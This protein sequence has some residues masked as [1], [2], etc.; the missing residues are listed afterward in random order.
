M[1]AMASHS[2]AKMGI[3]RSRLENDFAAFART[4]P[5]VY[6]VRFWIFKDW[7]S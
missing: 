7:K 4:Y 3:A 1:E 2:E 5:H 6:Q